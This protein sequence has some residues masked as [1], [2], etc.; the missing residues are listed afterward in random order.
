MRT[1]ESPD[2]IL[3][4]IER[5]KA[6]RHFAALDGGELAAQ[7]KRYA[8]NVAGIIKDELIAQVTL[9]PMQQEATALR[10]D[11][12]ATELAGP[13]PSPLIRLLAQSV[14][15]LNLE[16]DVVVEKSVR[17]DAA[18]GLFTS[19]SRDLWRLRDMIERRLNNMMRTLAYVRRVEGSSIGRTVSRLRVVG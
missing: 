19:I 18:G 1:I 14:A 3:Q 17:V 10:L 12:L 9:D 7:I 15:I 16:R 5:E 8:V 2:N 6:R 13:D 4:A 11:Q